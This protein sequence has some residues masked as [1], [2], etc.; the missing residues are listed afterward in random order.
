M[1]IKEKL[2]QHRRDFKVIYKCEHC[3]FEEEGGGYDDDNF[4]INV[5]PNKE[6]P[7]CN[8]KADKE[9]YVPLSTRYR[10]DETI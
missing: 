8:K 9:S 1:Y 4:H 3:G 2:S 7:K 10:E 6:C 5:I